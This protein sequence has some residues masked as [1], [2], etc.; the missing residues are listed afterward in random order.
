MLSIYLTSRDFSICQHHQVPSHEKSTTAQRNPGLT[1]TLSAVLL[2]GHNCAQGSCKDQGLF[3]AS[4]INQD[5][6]TEEIATDQP[7]HSLLNL[8]I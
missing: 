6:A 3:F 7:I 5:R 8:L 4:A 2:I 1:R